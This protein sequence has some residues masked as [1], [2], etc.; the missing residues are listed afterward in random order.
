MNVIRLYNQQIPHKLKDEIL[1]MFDKNIPDLSKEKVTAESP[2][3][4]LVRIQLQ[5]EISGYLSFVE[6][7][8]LPTELI[9]AIENTP[10]GNQLAGF[11]LYSTSVTGDEGAATIHYTVVEEARRR[12]GVLRSMMSTLTG[13]NPAVSLCCSIENVSI[14][15]SL[16]FYVVSAHGTNVRMATMPMPAD[17][18]TITVDMEE[19]AK[20]H[21]TESARQALKDRFGKKVRAEYDKF[22]MIQR[23]EAARVAEFVAQRRQ[24]RLQEEPV[25]PLS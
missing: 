8:S 1:E 21:L 9:G 10:D 3:Y 19:I 15:E 7:R 17:G 24:Q 16:G 18:Q 25:I 23:A 14:Y 11:L 2:L 12:Q 22:R 5:Q 20:S 13:M 6:E 4:A